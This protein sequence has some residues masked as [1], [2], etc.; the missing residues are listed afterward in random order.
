MSRKH[1]EA[2]AASLRATRPAIHAGTLAGDPYHVGNRDQ[3]N[4]TVAGIV[5][6]CSAANSR[7]S[8][9]RFVEACGGYC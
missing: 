6:V 9:S 2:L 8:P 5:G 7:F 4:F 3:W 1:F